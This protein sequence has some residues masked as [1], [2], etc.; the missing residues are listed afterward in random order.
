MLFIAVLS[1]IL[2][3]ATLSLLREW[4]RGG[5]GALAAETPPDRQREPLPTRHVVLASGGMAPEH[6][7]RYAG[8]TRARSAVRVRRAA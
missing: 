2:T 1:A 8:I 5:P 4:A 7:R 3:V 6:L